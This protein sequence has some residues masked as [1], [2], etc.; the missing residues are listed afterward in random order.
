M[1]DISDVEKHLKTLSETVWAYLFDLLPE[2]EQ[3]EWLGEM[4]GMEKDDDGFMT[5]PYSVHAI[6]LSGLWGVGKNTELIKLTTSKWAKTAKCS[7]DNALRDIQNLI[8][9]GVLEKESEG[10]RSTNY[11]LLSLTD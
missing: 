7:F 6:P 2:M 10:G 9:Q 11:T 1:I 5:F 8:S 3:T 4:I